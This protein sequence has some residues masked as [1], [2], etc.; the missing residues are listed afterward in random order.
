MSESNVKNF[1]EGLYSSVKEEGMTYVIDFFRKT[2]T[3]EV[4]EKKATE[5]VIKSYLSNPL[6][7]ILLCVIGFFV[8]KGLRR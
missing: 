7:I 8:F 4:I 1:F 2:P 5:Q 6:V 3:G